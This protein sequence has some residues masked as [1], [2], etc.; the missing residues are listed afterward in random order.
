MNKPSL[1]GAGAWAAQSSEW[2]VLLLL[3]A[4]SIPPVLIR[5]QS[6][7]V[8]PTLNLLDGSWVLDICY[9]AAHGV[10]L[11]RDVLF[12]YGPLYEWLSSAPSRWIGPSTG[13]ILATSSMLPTLVSV[14][15]IF[16]SSRLLLP[17]VSPWR[18][19]LFLA[20]MLWT[21]P[22]VRLAICLF[23]FVVFVRLA[24]AVASRA[25][26]IALPALVAAILCLACF[27]V[28]ADAGLYVIAAFLICVAVTAIVQ[29]KMP[30]AV[31][32]LCA[33]LVAAGVGLALL[34]VTTNA[35]MA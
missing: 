28:S 31:I 23:A 20:V 7:T 6:L 17:K 8:V 15:A 4:A 34:V 29:W 2:L 3:L 32:R 22:G 1:R 18:R 13:T 10:W 33:L 27:L 21:P 12:T 9:K 24:D 26:G 35:V 11:G 14:L 30:G 25:A 19:A 16:V 5:R